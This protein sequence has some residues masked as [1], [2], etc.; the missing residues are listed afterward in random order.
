MTTIF[1]IPCYATLVYFSSFLYP[2]VNP[3]I[4]AINIGTTHGALAMTTP[5]DTSMV[6]LE[7]YLVIISDV[8]PTA[9][10]FPSL[11]ANASASLKASFTV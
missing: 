1:Y 4:E 8:E 10:N 5:G 2:N 3:T 6:S 9:T 11:I 7:V